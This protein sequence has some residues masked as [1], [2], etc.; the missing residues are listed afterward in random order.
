MK[1]GKER[2]RRRD[3]ER[4]REKEGKRKGKKQKVKIWYCALSLETLSK[5]RTF[6][7]QIESL[8]FAPEK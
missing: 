1:S 6:T 4:V 7:C 5:V 3:R 2:E 8:I